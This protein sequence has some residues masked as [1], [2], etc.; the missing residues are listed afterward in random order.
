MF[1]APTPVEIGTRLIIVT[2]NTSLTVTGKFSVTIGSLYA[3]GS[4]ERPFKPMKK[5]YMPLRQTPKGGTLCSHLY[6]LGS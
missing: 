6:E 3:A 2:I 4:C 5:M 1:M